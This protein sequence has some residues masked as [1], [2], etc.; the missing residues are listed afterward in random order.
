MSRHSL[1]T[2]LLPNIHQFNFRHQDVA[3]A[4]G[5]RH[6]AV[7]VCLR[8]VSALQGRCGRAQECPGPV[9]LPQ[10]HS[11]IPGVIARCR[12]VLLKTGFVGFVHD[13]KA[14]IRKW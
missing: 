5:K 4:F 9:Q 7:F 14:K 2:M 10:H 6:Q 3:I 11:R 1:F 8:I 13:D 12:T